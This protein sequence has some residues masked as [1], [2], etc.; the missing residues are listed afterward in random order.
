LT[1]GHRTDSADGKVKIGIY[2]DPTE[3]E[4]N[5]TL[6]CNEITLGG[7]DF[8]R[9]ETKDHDERLKKKI[10]IEM[11]YTFITWPRKLYWKVQ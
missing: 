7:N 10:Q 9:W 6:K 5:A 11:Y 2:I 1:I 4:E 8:V 3:N